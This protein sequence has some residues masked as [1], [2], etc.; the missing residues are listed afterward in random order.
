MYTIQSKVYID[1]LC[2]IVGTCQAHLFYVPQAANA[3][4]VFCSTCMS[5]PEFLKLMFDCDKGARRAPLSQL[6]VETAVS[7]R[8]L[9]ALTRRSL[10]ERTFF[11]EMQD[12]SWSTVSTNRPGDEDSRK[13]GNRKSYKL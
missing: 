4:K 12:N 13:T 2:C 5:Y 1:S 3:R 6:G 9:G 11:L 8:L 10:Q 7:M